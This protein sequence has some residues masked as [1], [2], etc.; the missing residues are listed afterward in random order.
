MTHSLTLTQ[1]V[2]QYT[3]QILQVIFIFIAHPHQGTS[4]LGN[5]AQSTNGDSHMRGNS[6]EGEEFLLSFSF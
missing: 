1:W 6:A 4:E 5:P 2:I 3:F